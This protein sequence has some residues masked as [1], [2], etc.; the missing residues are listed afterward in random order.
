MPS[1]WM[2][3]TNV[4]YPTYHFYFTSGIVLTGDAL[5]GNVME[6]SGW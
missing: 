2:P 6:L 5:M 4:A 1:F 3:N